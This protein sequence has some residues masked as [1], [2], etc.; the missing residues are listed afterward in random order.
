MESFLCIMFKASQQKDKKVLK[1]ICCMKVKFNNIAFITTLK[2]SEINSIWLEAQNNDCEFGVESFCPQS[3]RT[4]QQCN[5]SM[6]YNFFFATYYDPIN[7]YCELITRKTVM[8][9][10][11]RARPVITLFDALSLNLFKSYSFDILIDFVFRFK[12]FRINFWNKNLHWF[13]NYRVSRKAGV[14]LFIRF[15][16]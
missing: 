12:N 7:V 15:C 11:G 6:T 3:L 5:I 16:A 9:W 13:W 10:P 14:L 8:N 4:S 1:R 2:M